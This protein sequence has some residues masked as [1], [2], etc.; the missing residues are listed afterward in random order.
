MDVEQL[1]T[2]RQRF[3]IYR[4][5]CLYFWPHFY[6]SYKKEKVVVGPFIIRNPRLKEAIL[7]CKTCLNS[8]YS[9][10]SGL[11]RIYDNECFAELRKFAIQFYPSFTHF[12]YLV[13]RKAWSFLKKNCVLFSI[14]FFSYFRTKKME[15]I[16]DIIVVAQPMQTIHDF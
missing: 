11:R 12:D 6:D 7:C 15:V 16:G 1:I 9:G 8:I 5:Q 13:K 2:M 4:E 14:Y 10:F 3:Q